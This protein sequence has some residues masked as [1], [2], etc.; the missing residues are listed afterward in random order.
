VTPKPRRFRWRFVVKPSFQARYI[1]LIF[2]A[3]FG[4]VLF[5]SWNIFFV[6]GKTAFGEMS[7]PRAMAIFQQMCRQL[8]WQIGLY[9]AVLGAG[10]VLVTHRLA[11]PL[12]RF[13]QSAEEVGRGRLRHRVRLRD[14]DEFADL[15]DRLNAMIEALQKMVAGDRARRD[16]ALK[17]LRALEAKLKSDPGARGRV[18]EAE[19]LVRKITEDFQI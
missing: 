14:W 15:K 2:A 16:E 19:E 17:K 6:F 7:D 18:R 13:E 1:V 9:A 10:A 5:G 3:V 4:V 8:A 11:G 12:Y